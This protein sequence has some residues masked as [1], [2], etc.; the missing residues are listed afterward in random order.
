MGLLFGL[1]LPTLLFFFLLLLNPI[2]EG[3]SS[4]SKSIISFLGKQDMPL[5]L[6]FLYFSLA[7]ILEEFIPKNTIIIALFEDGGNLFK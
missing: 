2:E 6:L 4:F 5:K 1:L 7:P 3:P